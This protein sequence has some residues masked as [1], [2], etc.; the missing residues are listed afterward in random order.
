MKKILISFFCIAT[1]VSMIVSCGQKYEE[2]AGNEFRGTWVYV[3]SAPDSLSFA[4]KGPVFIQVREIGG[5]KVMMFFT[6]ARYDSSFVYI[7]EE[8]RIAGAINLFAARINDTVR[9]TIPVLDE[10]DWPIVNQ[11]GEDSVLIVADN[12]KP[13]GTID[14]NSLKKEKLYFGTYSFETAGDSTRMLIKKYAGADDVKANNK[15][16]Q[17]IYKRP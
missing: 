14:V 4:T 2:P 16:P 9:D 15:P 13:M 3:G 12:K 7:E 6:N 1:T 10:N 17:D 8:S 5:E 11:A